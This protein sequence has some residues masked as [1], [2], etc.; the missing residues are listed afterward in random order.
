MHLALSLSPKEDTAMSRYAYATRRL[1]PVG[2]IAIT[3][4]LAQELYEHGHAITLCGNNV[5]AYHVFN[6]W[7]LGHTMRRCSMTEHYP[8]EEFAANVASFLSY[9]EKELGTYVVY[10]VKASAI[11]TT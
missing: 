9:L 5:H 4:P 3:K 10:Y 11:T 2:Y 1:A 6:G 7:Y 8:S